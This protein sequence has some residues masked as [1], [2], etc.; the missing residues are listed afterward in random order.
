MDTVKKILQRRSCPKCHGSWVDCEI[1]EPILK[2][3]A[4]GAFHSKLYG[5]GKGLWKCPQCLEVFQEQ[6]ELK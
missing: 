6:M 4:P 1:S 5:A 2:Y 3:C